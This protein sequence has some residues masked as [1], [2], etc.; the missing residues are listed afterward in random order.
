[1]S[2]FKRTTNPI[3]TVLLPSRN[4]FDMLL[5]TINSFANTCKNISNLEIIIKLD[6]DDT[7]SISRL[8][9]IRKDVNIKVII[10][11]QLN[12][13]ASLHEYANEMVKSATGDWCLFGNDDCL[14]MTKDWDDIIENVKPTES[15]KGT[16]NV[17]MLSI[18][19][20]WHTTQNICD[21]E[22]QTGQEFPVIRTEVC[23]KV[24]YFSKH[25]HVDSFLQDVYN[26][27]FA[28]INISIIIKH[29]RN[30]DFA[31]DITGIASRKSASITSP[32]YIPF[33]QQNG[34]IFIQDVK[35][36]IK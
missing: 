10:S 19:C 7:S 30:S 23:H 15:F 31:N 11:S 5:K 16:P 33:F 3:L 21:T 25:N 20:D 34:E 12:G 36:L 9:E 26:S 35:K 27:I 18:I 29:N 14:M 24:G 22:W 13:Y 17:G 6:D 1:M 32:T 2:Y 28:N 4:R 8:E